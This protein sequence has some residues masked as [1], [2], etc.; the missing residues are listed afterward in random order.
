MGR[1]VHRRAMKEN[2]MHR[3]PRRAAV[4]AVA[5]LALAPIGQ[6]RAMHLS[7]NGAVLLRYHYV[8]GQSYAYRMTLTMRVSMTGTGVGSSSASGPIQMTGSLRYHILRVEPDG[9]AL[10]RV[11][12]TGMIMSMTINGK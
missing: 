10:A 5:G 6:A 3:I 1:R 7:A 8:A 9:S 4:L 11:S 2:V 12:T